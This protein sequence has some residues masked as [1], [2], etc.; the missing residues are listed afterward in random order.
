MNATNRHDTSTLL[1]KV[2]EFGRWPAVHGVDWNEG[3]FNLSSLLSK[4]SKNRFLSFLYSNR[5]ID[6]TVYIRVRSNEVKLNN[7]GA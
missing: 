5:Q 2:E 4:I 1:K 6:N 3:E 7:F